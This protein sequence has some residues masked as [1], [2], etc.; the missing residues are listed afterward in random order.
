M[1][2]QLMRHF[3]PR[4]LAYR[5]KYAVE[6]RSGWL[7]RRDKLHAWDDLS[8]QACLSDA[9][10]AEPNR[11]LA[12]LRDCHTRF[13]FSPDDMHEYRPLLC[14]F[15]RGE[16]GPSATPQQI[17]AG[18]FRLFYV[19]SAK[20]GFP[21]NWHRNA[22]TGEQAPADRH[23][24]EIC[25]FD[26]GDIK[27]I[28]D[29]NRFAFAFDLVRAYGRTGDEG[30]AEIFWTLVEDWHVHN[31]PSRGAN[32]KC[33]QEASLRLMAWCFGLFGFLRSA[34]TTPNRVAQL[35][36]MVSHTGR[37]V[38]DN[39]DYAL[40]QNNNHGVSEAA[41]LWTIGLL[42]PELHHADRWRH[43][44]RGLLE[45][46]ARQLIYDD[47]AFSQHSWNYHRLML[48]D[49]IWSLRLGQL[50]GQVFAAEV[51]ERIHRAGELLYQMHDPRTGEVPC[52]GQD[53]G[54]L[55]LPLNNCS[56]FD[57]RPVLQATSVVTSDRRCLAEGPWDEDVLWLC[58]PT[59]SELSVEPPARHDVAA[60]DGGYFSLR[61]SDTAVFTR[62]ASFRHRPAQTDAL[63]VDLWW[64]GHNI[65]IDPGT[66][67]YNAPRPWNNPLAT[68][69]YHNTVT[70]DGRDQMTRA[71]RWMW[72]PWLR[73]TSMPHQH[74]RGG[75]LSYW[76]AEHD[77]YGRL[78]PPVW[79]CRGVLRIGDEH[80]LVL[81]RLQ[82]RG[83][84]SYR[85]HWLLADLPYDWDE[86]DGHIKLHTGEGDYHI[87]FGSTLS[88][89]ERSEADISLVRADEQSPRGWRARGY[90]RRAAAISIAA[91]VQAKH[92]W[93]WTVFGPS[94][95]VCASDGDT[96]DVDGDCWRASAHLNGEQSASSLVTRVS[97]SGNLS[98]ELTIR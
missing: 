55:I 80:W 26:Y 58:G 69:A 93:F 10:L 51:V 8:L 7:A 32:W 65:A 46:L 12:H 30:W 68:A 75:Q 37:R 50:N 66:F 57:Y 38:A 84:H 25:D 5:A 3:G 31:Q 17:A 20:T 76:Q 49:Y 19:L 85:L 90:Q 23:W 48:H 53:D 86:T 64:K 9:R 72:L 2:W 91:T 74:S 97:L 11:L 71:G 40:S 28:W 59:Y 88:E 22:L 36:K 18:E 78:R 4:W 95:A 15:D 6:R 56:Y 77:G 54:S 45:R 63:H 82:S 16:E 14:Q 1:A 89:G 41:G 29:L 33:G 24:S 34:A 87:R 52:Y 83:P 62:A 13:F 67:S 92:A 43:L 47:G 94:P 73:C 98:D 79:H 44:G 35:L 70:V 21:P 81:D 96:L 39:V 27:V 61:G 60:A 42:F